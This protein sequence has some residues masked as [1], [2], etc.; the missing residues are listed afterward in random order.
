MNELM[1]EDS[2]GKEGDAELRSQIGVL[3]LELFNAYVASGKA[4]EALAHAEKL[5]GFAPQQLPAIA[6][7]LV[8]S[9]WLEPEVFDLVR[10]AGEQDSN[11]KRLLLNLAKNLYSQK[12]EH[13]DEKEFAFLR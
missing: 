5:A 4:A 7:R 6:D 3:S 12:G 13:L 1:A 11:S 2:E 9:K 8:D 10:R